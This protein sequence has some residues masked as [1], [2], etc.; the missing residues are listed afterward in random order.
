M[1]KYKRV[2]FRIHT[3]MYYNNHSYGVGFQNQQD[4]ELFDITVT[5]IFLNDGWEI[6]KEKYKSSGSCTTVIKDKQEL[7]LHPQSFSGVV[8]EEN[9]SYIE[10][11][12]SNSCIFKF[13]KTDIYEDVFDITDEEYLKI[14][15]SK[16]EEIRNDL[17]EIYK[18]K[19]SNLY[20]TSY[21]PIDKIVSKY[22][23]SRLTHYVGVYSS[24]DIEWEFIINIFEDLKKDDMLISAKTRNGIGYRTTTAKELKA[25]LKEKSA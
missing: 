25:K 2:Y 3:Q 16:K 8:L 14:L 10:N 19:R 17:L 5:N 18:T 23:I 1:K 6:K 13:E 12:I 21:S 24:S 4:R 11:L 20:I 22:R 7:Y 9:I 15:E